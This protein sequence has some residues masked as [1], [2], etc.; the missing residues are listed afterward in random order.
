MTGHDPESLA[1]S[2]DPNMQFFM[3]HFSIIFPFMPRRQTW[4]V[5]FKY[6]N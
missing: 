1:T 2:P 3:M 5:R 4:F 6:F